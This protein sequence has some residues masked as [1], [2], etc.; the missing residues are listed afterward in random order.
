MIRSKR[1]MVY[2]MAKK[3]NPERWAGKTRNWLLP[4]IVTLNPDKKFNLKTYDKLIMVN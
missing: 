2:E 1:H 4:T 3:Q